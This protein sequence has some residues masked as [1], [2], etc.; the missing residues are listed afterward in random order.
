MLR[1]PSLLVLLL[2][3]LLLGGPA[4]G[5]DQTML[6]DLLGRLPAELHQSKKTEQESVEVLFRA[7][8]RRS[9]TE[10]EK[11]RVSKFLQ[12]AKKGQAGY[13][14]VLWALMNSKEFMQ[15]HGFAKLEEM[16]QFSE[17]IVQAWKKK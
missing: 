9:P 12:Q 1:R 17:K 10:A 7:A 13:E 15:V 8:L 14:D 5:A 3:G 11:D 4:R 2:L 16:I 6:A